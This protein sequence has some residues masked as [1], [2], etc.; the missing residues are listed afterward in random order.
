MK[1]AVT[2]TNIFIDLIKTNLL[3][4]L[5][6]IGVSITT[7]KEVINEL[8]DNQQSV[9]SPFIESGDLIVS[10]FSADDIRL[11]ES[12]PIPRGLSMVDA[13]LFLFA[14]TGEDYLILTNDQLLRSTCQHFHIEVHGVLWLMDLFFNQGLST[15]PEL[16]EALSLLMKGFHRLPIFE[17]KIRLTKWSAC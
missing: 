13:G 11:I 7:T 2:D 15:G 3:V 14:K 8:L 5:F 10:S 1:I 6:K 16:F 12:W 4:N 9:L 17:C